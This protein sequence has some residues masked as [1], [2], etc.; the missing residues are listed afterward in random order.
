MKVSRMPVQHPTKHSKSP[1]SQAFLVFCALRRKYW[2]V[3]RMAMMRL[4]R[5][6]EP[7]E[8]VTARSSAVR[9]GDKPPLPKYLRRCV[10]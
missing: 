1:R 3:L 5:Q 9:V 10:W 4:P 8:K 2:A 7:K 6:I